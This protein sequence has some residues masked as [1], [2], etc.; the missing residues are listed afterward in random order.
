[1]SELIDEGLLN[2]VAIR[3]AR[4]LNL[5]MNNRTL[6]KRIIGFAK[7]ATDIDAFTE[8]ML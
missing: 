5:D 6:G 1:M 8:C 4:A 7:S 2:D 3:V